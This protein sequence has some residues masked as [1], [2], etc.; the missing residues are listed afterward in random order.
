MPI[1][2]KI[3]DEVKVKE[4]KIPTLVVPAIVEKHQVSVK[5]P[6]KI[7]LEFDIKK[8]DKF[9]LTPTKPNKIILEIQR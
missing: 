6:P 2:K 9:K 4:R 3:W 1:P 8:G 7:V 5:L